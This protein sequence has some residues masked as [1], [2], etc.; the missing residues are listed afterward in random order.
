MAGVAHITPVESK[1]EGRS[2][3][4]ISRIF[5][6]VVAQVLLGLTDALLAWGT[7]LLA[8]R[9]RYL[10]WPPTG[11]DVLALLHP[12]EMMR[13]FALEAF[14]PYLEICLAAPLPLILWLR[15]AR[16]YA[17]KGA[18]SWLEDAFGVLRA[19]TMTSLVLIVIA[20]MYR[21]VFEFREF[22]YSRGIFLM[23]WGLLTLTV[24]GV[25]ALVR[26]AQVLAR[27]RGHNLIPAVLVGEGDLAELCLS[28]MRAKPHLGYRI[29]GVLSTSSTPEGTSSLSSLR[30]GRVE[31]LPE[32]VRRFRI[33]QVFITD[34]ALNPDLLFETI[35]RCWRTSRVAFSVVPN[36]L[37][38]LPSKTELDQVGALP[39]IKL[40]QEPLRGPNRYLKRA[41]DVVLASLGLILLSPWLLLI[42]ALIKLDSRGPI[43]FRQE[44]VGMDGRLFT[45]Y[46][47]RTMRADADERPHRELMADIIR[48]SL[49]A[50]SGT[51]S[52]GKPGEAHPERDARQ[53]LYGKVPNDHRITRVGRWLRRWSL[54]EL[55]QLINVLKGEMSLVGPRPPIPYEVEHYSSWHRKR[56]EVKPGITGLW[57]VSG[58]NRLPFDRMVELDLYY[59]EHWSLWLDLKILL[60]TL[61]AIFR[62]ETE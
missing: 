47:F 26:R 58:R 32:I 48:G 20:F 60:L 3:S 55:P 16:L 56:L 57:Q 39:M 51:A 18:F 6:P 24:L 33:E 35:L 52:P 28:E 46:K 19:T 14:R 37:S 41:F 45:L 42:A 13:T 2:E 38:C 43:L 4:A 12:G 29:V 1:E 30:V 54:D 8:Y 40:F 53:M 50:V 25:R 17:L 21:G 61:P 36:L 62:G 44:R 34:P 27:R 11:S 10:P 5:S 7:F 59:I 23:H 31:D 9:L 49:R 22:S 15:S